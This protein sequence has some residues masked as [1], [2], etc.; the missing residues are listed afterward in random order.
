MIIALSIVMS[1]LS[2][3][4]ALNNSDSKTKGL[5]KVIMH[6]FEMVFTSHP[7]SLFL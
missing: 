7:Y 6:V 1:R 2:S 3:S 5:I 4:L